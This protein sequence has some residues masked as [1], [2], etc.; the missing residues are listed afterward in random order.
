MSDV[1]QVQ[2]VEDILSANDH[3]A[4]E[5]RR[6]LDE[7]DVFGVNIMSSPG[8]GKTSTIVATQERLKDRLRL[9]MVDGDIATTIDADRAADA[10]MQAIQ[11]NTGGTCHLD[12]VMLSGALRSLKLDETDLMIVE[13]VGNLICPSNFK[14]GT[15]ISVLIASIPEGADKPYK[16]PPMYRG[17]NA[18]IINKIDLMP[19]ID[20][21]MDYFIKG[22]E[23]LN[24]GLK[25]FP[26]SCKTGEGIDEWTEW[27]YQQVTNREK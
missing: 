18:L 9:S 26:I 2:I 21:D 12:A 10:G 7:N 19:Y 5:N 22:V 16:Y 13:N 1:K 23:M 4:I 11:V 3:L 8:S 27:L 14:L 15:H 6:I 20:F 24:P 17:V 25:S